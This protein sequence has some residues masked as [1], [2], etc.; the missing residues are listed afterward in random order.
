VNAHKHAHATRLDIL[1]GSGG[2]DTL[3]LVV[4]DDGRGFDVDAVEERTAH[5]ERY[6]LLGME[7]RVAG[8]GGTFH[9]TSRPGFGTRVEAF[10][11]L[12]A[13]V[14]EVLEHDLAVA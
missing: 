8:L 4:A 11:P 6:G 5:G 12:K 9:V 13:R 3:R 14:V 10:L 7:E 2:A 1:V